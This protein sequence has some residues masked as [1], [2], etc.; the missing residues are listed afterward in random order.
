MATATSVSPG[1]LNS[2]FFFTIPGAPDVITRAQ[3]QAWY[4]QPM[5]LRDIL[6]VSK[7]RAAPER[8]APPKEPAS[9]QHA[10]WTFLPACSLFTGPGNDLSVPTDHA[11]PLPRLTQQGWKGS[12]IQGCP[13]L[14]AF[15]KSQCHSLMVGGDSP[16]G[17]RSYGCIPHLLA[18]LSLGLWLPELEKSQ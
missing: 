10:C 9:R 16:S 14:S 2:T 8:R 5:A 4:S 18:G 12:L 6:C 11:S 3:S 15:V 1:S 17:D 13:C 7:H